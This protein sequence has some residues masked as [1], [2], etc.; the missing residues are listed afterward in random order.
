ML[1]TAARISW[2]TACV[3][4]RALRRPRGCLAEPS[5]DL[6]G[7]R[8]GCCLRLAL[9]R[10]PVG[11]VEIGIEGPGTGLTRNVDVN[12]EQGPEVVAL[13]RP[14]AEARQMR[15]HPLA[16][17]EVIAPGG[18]LPVKGHRRDLRSVFDGRE[19]RLA[20]IHLADGEAVE[21]AHQAPLLVPHLDRVC[22]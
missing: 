18:E 19:L 6:Q 17:A 10:R 20:E 14:E 1:R 5:R 2:R 22:K 13:H 3:L 15:R 8:T 21:P 4:R 11:E 9:A 12:V 7:C 16:V